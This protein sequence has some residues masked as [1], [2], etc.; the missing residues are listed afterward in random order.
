MA[1]IHHVFFWLVNPSSEEDLN[2]LLEGIKTL[3]NIEVVTKIHVGVPATT[4][5]RSVVE[6]SYSASELLFFDTVEDQK[7]YQDH[8]VHQKFVE[9]CSHLWQKVVVYDTIDV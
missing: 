9:Q 5:D 2:K 8:P 6:S 1:V 3:G 4:E 7:T